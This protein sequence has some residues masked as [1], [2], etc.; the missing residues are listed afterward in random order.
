MQVPLFQPEWGVYAGGLS[1]SGG[2]ENITINPPRSCS[3]WEE[4]WSIEL[5][6]VVAGPVSQDN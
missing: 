3:E 1:F 6:G 5:L 4:E 2:P